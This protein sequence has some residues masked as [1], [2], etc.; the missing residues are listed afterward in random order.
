M[1]ADGPPLT[2]VNVLTDAS[3]HG[4]L[5]DPRAA[6]NI[7]PSDGQAV[8]EYGSYLHLLTPLFALS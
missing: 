6:V 3:A 7:P 4:L 1:V 8:K 2:P 5:H